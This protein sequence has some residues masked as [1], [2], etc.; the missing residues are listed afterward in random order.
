MKQWF[1]SVPGD[2]AA[3]NGE[4]TRHDG[5]RGDQELMPSELLPHSQEDSAS[6][7]WE[8]S[9]R[10]RDVFTCSYRQIVVPNGLLY[11]YE[12]INPNWS[13]QRSVMS[14]EGILCVESCLKCGARLLLR[15]IRREVF[16][17]MPFF[18]LA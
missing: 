8:E 5:D 1:L 6:Q 18:F 11:I 13:A 7:G 10:M 4:S 2:I 12:C 17:V 9:R 16:Q 15:Q 3:V 14:S